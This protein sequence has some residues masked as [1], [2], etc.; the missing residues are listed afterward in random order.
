VKWLNERTSYLRS[1]SIVSY[2][3]HDWVAVFG[4][5]EVHRMN[6]HVPGQQWRI[7]KWLKWDW[8]LLPFFSKIGGGGGGGKGGPIVFWGLGGLATAGRAFEMHSAPLSLAH[9]VWGKPTFPCRL[10]RAGVG[11]M[12]PQSNLLVFFLKK[13]ACCWFE[14]MQPITLCL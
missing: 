10:A 1:L 11:S 7:Q 12:P 5:V 3:G 9:V 13:K 4:L 6:H 14:S 2:L 8:F